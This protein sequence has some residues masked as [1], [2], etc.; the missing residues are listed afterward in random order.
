MALLDRFR[1]HP[2]HKNPDAAAR[3]QFV[4]ELPLDER[5]L[6]LEVARE[7]WVHFRRWMPSRENPSGLVDRSGLEALVAG[8]ITEGHE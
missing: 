2:G 8:S 1:T 4:Q 5:D 7:R 3:L 6:L